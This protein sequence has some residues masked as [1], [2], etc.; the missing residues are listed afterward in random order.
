MTK[1]LDQLAL[2]APELDEHGIRCSLARQS[3]RR[4]ERVT[5]LEK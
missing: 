3:L 1:L 4:T 2:F 5:L